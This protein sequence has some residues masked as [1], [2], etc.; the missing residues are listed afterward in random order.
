LRHAR[1]IF[2]FIDGRH[3]DECLVHA[4]SPAD[5]YREP[6]RKQ[7]NSSFTAMD[8]GMA[9]SFNFTGAAV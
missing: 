9:F 5:N 3:D 1:E 2:P 6:H 7:V 4:G 8:T